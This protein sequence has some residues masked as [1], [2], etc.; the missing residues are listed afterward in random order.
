MT[1]LVHRYSLQ[2]HRR[3]QRVLASSALSLRLSATNKRSL[4]AGL[5][6][7]L[8]N[9]DS[10]QFLEVLL[11][12]LQAAQNLFN[13]AN[14]F[15]EVL[16]GDTGSTDVRTL[17]MYSM[18]SSCEI[19][20]VDVGPY[21]FSANNN[22]LVARFAQGSAL[23]F[24]NNDI[25]FTD[26][27]CLLRMYRQ[28]LRDSRAIH[29]SELLYPDGTVQHGGVGFLRH[30]HGIFSYHLR[31]RQRPEHTE[32]PRVV[33]ALTGAL[34]LLSRH[35]FLA[36]GG[37]DVAYVDECQDIDL[38]LKLQRLGYYM[39]LH[40]SSKVVHHENGTRVKGEENWADRS[41][42]N[43]KWSSFLEIHPELLPR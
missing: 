22:T 40:G 27:S 32:E 30:D 20:V 41:L 6:V 17:A 36:V 21:H 7:L 19:K 10:P 34:I 11:P 25:E 2:A 5:S 15:F 9:K 4:K 3:A 37:F 18:F 13:D 35:S 39:L 29:G 38:C 28:H 14:L 43:N 33:P 31:H 23:L 24:L 8:L 12:Q 42:F 1:P 26:P 16:I